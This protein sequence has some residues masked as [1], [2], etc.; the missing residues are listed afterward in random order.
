MKSPQRTAVI[1][2]SAALL[3]LNAGCTSPGKKTAVGAGTGAAAGGVIGGIAGGWEG[4]AIG[5]GVGAVTGG[6]IGNVM[7]KQAKELAEVAETKRTAQGIVVNL[8]NDLLFETGKAEVKPEA[9]EQLTQLGAILAKYPQ[10]TINIMGFTDSTGSKQMNQ[11]LSKSRAEAVRT[12]LAS[13]GVKFN[14]MTVEGLGPSNPIASNDSAAGRAKN[15]RV[16]L[17]ISMPDKKTG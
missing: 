16:E 14:Q 1:V 10:D 8:K 3:I 9:K 7:D 13:Q 12:I 11:L 6:A 2:T 17:K 15:R 4:A 5:A